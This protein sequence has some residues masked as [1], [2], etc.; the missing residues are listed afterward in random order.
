MIDLH[1]HILPGMDDGAR[2]META[3]HMA[4]MA[5]QSGVSAMVV[6]PHCVSDRVEQVRDRLAELRSAVR[7]ER[8][9]IRLYSGMEIFGRP[10]TAALLRE[11]RLLT[12]NGSRY[13]LIEFAFDTDGDE[14]TA[15]LQSV[16]RA[17]YIPLVAHPERYRCIQEDPEQVN[18]WA[19]MGCRFQVNRGSL[20][21]R[22]GP[23]AREVAWAL[24]GRGFATV[25]ASD[26]HS[27][28]RR[29]PWLRDVWEL[30]EQRLSPAAAM[31]LLEENP[32]R[33]INNERLPSAEPEWF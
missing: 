2:D 20:L 27:A 15:V 21:G 12:I 1:S 25:V 30:L 11:G 17:G 26:S 29:T 33:I 32:R 3:L 18:L 31:W 19:R 22:F 9:P 23:E 10:D 24:A 6:T 28:T 7:A 14:E 5:V 16:I 8:I 13:P 4:D